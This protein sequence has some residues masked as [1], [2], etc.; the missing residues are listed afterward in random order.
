MHLSLSIHSTL[1]LASLQ[2]RTNTRGPNFRCSGGG[3]HAAGVAVAIVVQE[4]RCKVLDNT[5]TCLTVWGV[6]YNFVTGEQRI[7]CLKREVKRD[8]VVEVFSLFP[9][10][11]SS[12]YASL[13]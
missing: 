9:E 1:A 6:S 3:A 8:F 2:T 12:N 7:Q 11:A 5:S 4:P 13:L 10:Q